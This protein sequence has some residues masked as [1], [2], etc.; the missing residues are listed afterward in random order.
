MG[1]SI[2]PRSVI[3]DLSRSSFN[4]SCV[5]REVK[6]TVPWNAFLNLYIDGRLLVTCKIHICLLFFRIGVAHLATVSQVG[7]DAWT[8]S[9]NAS[10]PS[11]EDALALVLRGFDQ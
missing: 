11:A 8:V 6:S 5:E 4:A 10:A 7:H 1:V 2:F 3:A 9:A